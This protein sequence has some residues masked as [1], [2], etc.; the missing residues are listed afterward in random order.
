MTVAPPSTAAIKEQ[1]VDDLQQ[2]IPETREVTVGGE[3]VQVGALKMRQLSRVARHASGLVKF[4]K[5][6]GIDFEGLLTEGAEDLI[7]ALAAATDKPIE[8]IG[9]LNLDETVRLTRTV[10][11]V[12]ADFFAQTVLP[13]IEETAEMAAR[14][15]RTSSSA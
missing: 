14:L 13:E 8:W 15:G 11:E 3:T 5:G 7:A 6:E 12:N 1:G 4:F 2:V 10:V 9:E